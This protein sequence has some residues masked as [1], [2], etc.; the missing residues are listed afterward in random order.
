MKNIFNEHLVRLFGIIALVAV[1]GFSMVACKEEDEGPLTGTTWVYKVTNSTN[2]ATNTYSFNDSSKG[3]YTLSGQYLD[4]FTNKWTN[5][6]PTSN[7]SFTYVFS[8]EDQAGSIDTND[9]N[10]RAFTI[11]GNTMTVVRVRNDGSNVGIGTYT[12]Q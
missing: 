11:S 5:Y 10:K 12:R 8:E 4:Y 7:F 2:R 3:N 6:A 9:G 1:I